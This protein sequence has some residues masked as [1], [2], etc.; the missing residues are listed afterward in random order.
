MIYAQSSFYTP[1]MPQSLCIRK[2]KSTIFTTPLLESVASTNYQGFRQC[3]HKI[4]TLGADA[5]HSAQAQ[6][7]TLGS[8]LQA[9]LA[10]KLQA[11]S[12]DFR[13]KQTNYLERNNSFL[14]L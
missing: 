11:L 5:K 1:L 12:G 2:L 13:T 14:T 4:S 10:A 6:E 9:G 3:Q 7:K 8:N